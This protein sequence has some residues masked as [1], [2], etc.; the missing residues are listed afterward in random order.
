MKRIF[1]IDCPGVVY[2]VGDDEVLFKFITVEVYLMT[3]EVYIRTIEF[4]DY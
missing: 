2:D 3:V 1:L 4:Y